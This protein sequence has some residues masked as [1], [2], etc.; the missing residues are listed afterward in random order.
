MAHISTET[1]VGV[2]N[3]L[4]SVD[5]ADKCLCGLGR[6]EILSELGAMVLEHDVQDVIGVRLLHNHNLI[7]EDETM[8]EQEELDSEGCYCLSTIATSNSQLPSAHAATS[9]KLYADQF[10]PLEY[11]TDPCVVINAGP[12]KRMPAFFEKFAALLQHKGVVNLLGPCIA[13]RNFYARHHPDDTAILV[14]TTDATRRANVLKFAAPQEHDPSTLI[15]TSWIFR[16]VPDARAGSNCVP[17]C[18]ANC[19]TAT[20]C[21]ADSSGQHTSQSSHNRGHFKKLHM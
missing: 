2:Y 10:V 11:S 21:V 5:L 16:K 13:P 19:V 7:S 20:S 8:L 17:L 3:G 6:Y 15:Q 1:S 4:G 14:E 12:E 18:G 9:W